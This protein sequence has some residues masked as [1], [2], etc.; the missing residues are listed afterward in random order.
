M[1]GVNTTGPTVNVN[2]AKSYTSSTTPTADAVSSGSYRTPEDFGYSSSF[3]G[4]VADMITGSNSKA[5]NMAN[6]YNTYI[7]NER[8]RLWYTEMDNTKYQRMV[9]DAKAAGINPYYLM[10]S[11]VSSNAS[12]TSG[13]APTAYSSKEGGFTSIARI[14]ALALTAAKIFGV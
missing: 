10:N 6:A 4:A 14:L 2:A 13:S 7:N 8:N 5:E 9:A 1:I 11:G 3:G 12:S